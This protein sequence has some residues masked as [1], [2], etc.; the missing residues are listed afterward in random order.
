MYKRQALLL[1]V[2]QYLSVVPYQ[3][4]TQKLAALVGSHTS[5]PV[6]QVAVD[7]GCESPEDDEMDTDHPADT[8]ACSAPEIIEEQIL[9]LSSEGYSQAK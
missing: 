5:D 7:W 8:D 1:V 3:L 2:G 6:P 9:K 4:G